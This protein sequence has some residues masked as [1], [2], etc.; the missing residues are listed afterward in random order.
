MSGI[1]C[2]AER[3]LPGGDLLDRITAAQYLGVSAR[4]LD[5]WHLLNE[6]PPRIKLR[7]T[8]RYRL[9]SLVSWLSALEAATPPGS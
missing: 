9:D 3:T 4:T 2:S 7:G 1:G 5:R 6:G 8:V